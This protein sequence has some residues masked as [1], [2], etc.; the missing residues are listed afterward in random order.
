[1]G[2]SGLMMS[3]GYLGIFSKIKL[4]WHATEMMNG[5]CH[6]AAD[7]WNTSALSG[8]EYM[9]CLFSSYNPGNGR[10]L[11]FQVQ[12]QNGYIWHEGKFIVSLRRKDIDTNCSYPC[13]R[14][15]PS[16]ILCIKQ[17]N[18]IKCRKRCQRFV[19]HRRHGWQ[20]QFR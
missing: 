20:R 16:K 5:V 19:N 12:M 3:N 9:F 6:S 18:D 1:M 2:V 13:M 8:S 4:T 7:C 14:V 17:S 10:M 15:Y 11:S